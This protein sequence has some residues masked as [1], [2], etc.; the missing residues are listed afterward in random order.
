MKRF[1]RNSR[2]HLLL[3]AF[4]LF[5][6]TTI[7]GLS[8]YLTDTQTY[9]GTFRTTKGQELGFKISG[10]AY[11]N[12]I[13]VPGDSVTLDA[14]AEV[15]GDTPLYV[16]VKID[17]PAAFEINGLNSRWRQISEDSPIYYY[18]TEAGLVALDKTNTH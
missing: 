17:T 18:G 1:L 14:K 9:Q 16:F 4:S 6:V 5:A 3:L 7:F 10:K 2:L 8:A 13:V 12:S 15:S 11:E